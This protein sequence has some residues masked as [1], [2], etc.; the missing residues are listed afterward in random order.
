MWGERQ[1]FTPAR[2]SKTRGK[3]QVLHE[4]CLYVR[5]QLSSIP[6]FQSLMTPYEKRRLVAT[7]VC[8]QGLRGA[9]RTQDSRQ[10]AALGVGIGIV[11]CIS[12]PMGGR[13]TVRASRAVHGD[14]VCS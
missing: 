12:R 9:G 8:S 13:G 10:A 5:K 14:R 4:S 1:V 2:P 7:A 11:T 6:V 3:A